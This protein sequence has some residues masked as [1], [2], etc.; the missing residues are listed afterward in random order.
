MDGMRT[1]H[2]SVTPNNFVLSANVFGGTVYA[3][4]PTL[5][6]IVG[7]F[8]VDPDLATGTNPRRQSRPNP[9]HVLPFVSANDTIRVA[10]PDLGAD[11]TF[12][13]RVLDSS[14]LRLIDTVRHTNG[15][16]PRHAVHHQPSGKLFV[17]NELSQTVS[18]LCRKD[19]KKNKLSICDRRQLLEG[20]AHINGSAAAI[21]LSQDWR[22]LYVSVR[23]D[24]RE[25]PLHGRIVAFSLNAKSGTIVKK[26]GEW[27][28]LGV[29]P[30][31]FNIV[32]NVRVKGSCRSYVIVANRDSNNV[33][34]LRRFRKTGKLGKPNMTLRSI[35]NPSSVLQI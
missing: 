10:V 3:F 5:K 35:G 7:K 29:H 23:R 20:G 32:E 6:K 1:A 28:S 16:G 26:V 11:R 13:L 27:S 15:D 2:V 30:R 17:V 33:V 4:D 12:I 14:A 22:F 9:H 34:F 25:T 31:D 24:S 19:Q 8:T 18:T 21:R